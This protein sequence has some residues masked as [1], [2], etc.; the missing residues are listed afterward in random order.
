MVEEVV[1]SVI[2]TGEGKWDEGEG[3]PRNASE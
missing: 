3:V 2:G 1:D